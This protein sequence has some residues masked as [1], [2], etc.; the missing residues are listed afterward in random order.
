MLCILFSMIYMQDE[1]TLIRHNDMYH[2]HCT[3]NTV[4]IL[5][6]KALPRQQFSVFTLP[7]S[8]ILHSALFT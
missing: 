2:L 6:P 5:M 3:Y 1:L 7:K 4:P 8:Q